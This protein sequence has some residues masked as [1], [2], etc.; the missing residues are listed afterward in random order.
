M[1]VRLLSLLFA[2]PN[3]RGFLFADKHPGERIEDVLENWQYARK[4]HD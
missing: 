2:P 3:A 4:D 1:K